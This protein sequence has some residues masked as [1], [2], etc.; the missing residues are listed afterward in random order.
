MHQFDRSPLNSSVFALL[1]TA[2]A[3]LLS[4]VFRPFLDPDTF[5]LFLLTIW[6]SAWFYGRAGGAVASAGSA[7]A[8]LIFFLSPITWIS[9]TR[10]AAFVGLASL[11]T[12]VTASWRDSRR[13]FSS[14]LSS[15]ADAV[16]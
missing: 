10:L 7:V 6:A 11:L 3:L 5:S 14:T 8:L 2:F 4:L 12:W 16:V 9:V 15:I 13:L 1:L